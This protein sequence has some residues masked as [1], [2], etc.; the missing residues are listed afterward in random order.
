MMTHIILCMHLY[1]KICIDD[2]GHIG[3]AWGALVTA[4]CTLSSII[5]TERV[6]FNK[7]S[8]RRRPR[9]HSL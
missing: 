6:R 2:I 7:S 1:L 8:R 5:K 3:Y 9:L 4:T